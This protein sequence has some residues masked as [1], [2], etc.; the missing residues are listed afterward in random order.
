MKSK[1]W[2][3]LRDPYLLTFQILAKRLNLP[4]IRLTHTQQRLHH[5]QIF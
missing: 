1:R 2:S 3:C 4:P 5:T